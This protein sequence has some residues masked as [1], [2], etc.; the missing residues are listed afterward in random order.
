MAIFEC[1]SIKCK[2]LRSIILNM[3]WMNEMQLHRKFI[4]LCSSYFFSLIVRDTKSY[5]R[6]KTNPLLSCKRKF[7]TDN[8][9]EMLR[10]ENCF[11]K[12]KESKHNRPPI[13]LCSCSSWLI[14]LYELAEDGPVIWFTLGCWSKRS[15]SC[16]SSKLFA[17]TFASSSSSSSSSSKK[18]SAK[19]I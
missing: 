5:L 6:K 8:M 2:K 16:N 7:N 18:H 17:T 15:D 12:T 10:F 19:I 4:I 9:Q 11:R 3:C 1:F 14:A 13:G